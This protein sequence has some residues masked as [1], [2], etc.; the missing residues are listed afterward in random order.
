M[1]KIDWQDIRDLATELNR[2][3]KTLK[4]IEHDPFYIGETQRAEAEWFEE[5]YREYGIDRGFHLRRIHYR[6]ATHPWPVLD[7]DGEPYRNDRRSWV[8]LL[9]ASLYARYLGLIPV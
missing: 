2:P 9:R 4:V 6:L 7:G 5:I 8:G 3:I 1:D